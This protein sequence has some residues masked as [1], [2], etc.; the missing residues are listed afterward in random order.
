MRRLHAEG[1]SINGLARRFGMRRQSVKY[2]LGLW[3]QKPRPA[4]PGSRPQNSAAH[5]LLRTRHSPAVEAALCSLTPG[6]RRLLDE[7]DELRRERGLK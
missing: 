7:D 2:R 6:F 1:W 5:Y 4:R 3:K